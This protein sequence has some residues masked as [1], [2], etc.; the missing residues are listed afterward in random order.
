MNFEFLK[1]KGFEEVPNAEKHQPVEAQHHPPS[2][3]GTEKLKNRK[4]ILSVKNR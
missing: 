4:K 3:K 1:K 2:T